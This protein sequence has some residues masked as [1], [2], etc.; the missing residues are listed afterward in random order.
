[1][2][3]PCQVRKKAQADE[4]EEGWSRN[5]TPQQGHREAEMLQCR[6]RL[7]NLTGGVQKV[8]VVSLE[9]KEFKPGEG[10]AT[11]RWARVPWFGFSSLRA[12]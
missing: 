9:S 12:V 2:G 7:E 8:T 4:L 3:S 6:K 1:M 5:P 11:K 10:M